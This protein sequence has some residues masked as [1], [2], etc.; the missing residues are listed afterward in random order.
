MIIYHSYQNN[1]KAG[2]FWG[3]SILPW[4]HEPR[5]RWAFYLAI[6]TPSNG[7]EYVINAAPLSVRVCLPTTLYKKYEQ[8]WWTCQDSLDM[9]KWTIGMTVGVS[10]ITIWIKVFFSGFGLFPAFDYFTLLKLDVRMFALLECFLS[11]WIS[12]ILLICKCCLVP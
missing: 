6:S 9:I 4:Q 7:E 2:L 5:H 1:A 3:S 12:M 8:N 10:R 11:S